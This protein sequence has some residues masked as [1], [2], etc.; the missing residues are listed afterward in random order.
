MENGTNIARENLIAHG[1]EWHIKKQ[2]EGWLNT[3]FGLLSPQ[4]IREAGLVEQGNTWAVPYEERIC[5]KKDNFHNKGEKYIAI[6]YQFLK[7]YRKK[8]TAPTL[9]EQ[10]DN[11]I[12]KEIT[13]EEEF[14]IDNIDFG[15]I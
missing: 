7:W 4:D 3:V 15:N 14:S 11:E 6:P 10:I 1:K 9:D 12:E 8:F 13:K 5:E 2:Q